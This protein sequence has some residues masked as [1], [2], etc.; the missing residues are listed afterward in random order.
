MADLLTDLDAALADDPELSLEA[1]FRAPK[2]APGTPVLSNRTP[3][4][5]RPP[6]QKPDR[7]SW[8]VD[9]GW[10]GVAGGVADGIFG[11]MDTVQTFDHSISARL[12]RTLHST[13]GIHLPGGATIDADGKYRFVNASESFES[14]KSDRDGARAFMKT[15]LFKEPERTGAKI[16]RDISEFAANFVPM[17]V[18]TEGMAGW[19]YVAAWSRP[20]LASA[21]AAYQ[22]TDPLEGNLANVAEHFG[23]EKAAIS[24]MLHVDDLV[25]ALSVEQDDSEFE[26]RLKNMA[27]D[28]VVGVAADG[29]FKALGTMIGA[30]RKV[31]VQKAELEALEGAAEVKPDVNTA[32]IREA[33]EDDAAGGAKTLAEGAEPPPSVAKPEGP[34]VPQDAPAGTQGELFERPQSAAPD[35]LDEFERVHLDVDAKVRGMTEVELRQLAEDQ[36][37]GRGFTMLERMGVNP[38]RLDF[39][40]FLAKHPNAAE[41]MEALHDWVARIATAAEPMS[42]Q[43]GSKPRTAET[44]AVLARFLG[45]D[46]KTISKTF[47]DKTKNLDVYANAAAGLIGGEAEK[48]VVLAEKAVPR[49]ADAG[50]PEYIAFLKQLETVS[51]LQA[52]F[53]GSASNMGRGLRSLQTIVESRQG[54]A[55]I[56]RIKSVLGKDPAD[57]TAKIGKTFEDRLT[58]LGEAKTPAARAKLLQQI[59]KQ[60]GDLARVVR[61]ATKYSGIVGKLRV[62]RETSANLFSPATFT[63]N[64]LGGA[65]M[66]TSDIIA[67]STSHLGAALFRSPE[68]VAAA[69]SN[70]AYLGSLLPSL[71]HGTVRSTQYLARESIAEVRAATEGLGTN[72]ASAKLTQASS[73]VERQ[74]GK[75]P[76]W[77]ADKLGKEATLG[78]LR[79]KFERADATRERLWHIAPTTVDAWNA[80]DNHGAAFLTAGL[81]SLTG[82]A[83]NTFGAIS[84]S[85]RVLAID[86][87]DELIGQTV[88]DASRYAEA[89]RQ[90]TLQG[91]QLGKS[92]TDLASFAERQAKQLVSEASDDTLT[93]LEQLVAAGQQDAGKIKLLAQEALDRTNIE[94]VAEADARRILFQDDLKT[95]VAQGASRA[96]NQMDPGG[97]IVPFV[98]TPL[99]IIE[100]AA[101]EFTPAGLFFR[102]ARETIAAGGPEAAEMIARM[103]LG[104][105]LI[106]EGY[107]RAAKGDVVGY[108]GGPTSSSRLGRP[109]YSIRLPGGNHWEFGRIDPLAIPLGLGADLYEWEQRFEDE[110]K[111]H[112]KGALEKYTYAVMHAVTSSVLSK[113][114]L[115]S[116]QNFSA[117]ADPK[118]GDYSREQFFNGLM[119]RMVPAGGFQKYAAQGDAD[120]IREAKTLAEKYRASWVGL[121][122]ALPVRRDPLLGKVVEFNRT[123]GFRRGEDADD[124]LI[125]EVSRLNFEAPRDTRAI[126][127][128]QLTAKHSERLKAL[129]GEEVRLGGLTLDGRLRAH[130]ANPRWR[131]MSDYQ[132]VE[133]IRDTREMYAD[134]AKTRLQQEDKGLAQEVKVQS[135]IRLLEQRG[136]TPDELPAAVQ[137]FR[138]EA[139][140]QE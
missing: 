48:L 88:F 40:K 82:L 54:L 45:S 60:R 14:Y 7:P 24:K 100:S 56:S 35:V 111:E 113:S 33:V 123:A 18:A 125:A 101:M 67:A 12:D 94:S 128:V 89:V 127:G 25:G 90:A 2:P 114:W 110:D 21:V 138:K 65:G 80:S 31:K 1:Q 77:E 58:A 32:A 5:Y 46:I 20:I 63:F 36:A 115:K 64:I 50:S 118:T 68:W 122:A 102:E 75:I 13:L 104:T 85:A 39:G 44:T 70:R 87:P 57:A 95:G 17:M 49:V 84:R 131:T 16:T 98:K 30:L 129:M 71:W 91:L 62:F 79:P 109:Q 28:G 53:R 124:Q 76:V 86:V 69:A 10:R 26:A 106:V 73:W 4:P 96:L 55:K 22:K 136:T 93:R 97:I 117:M 140:S 52:A 120:A 137:R 6:A 92:G 83:F 34:S 126:A 134:V 108:D 9:Y 103:T 121:S 8:A 3:E 81:R 72:V 59:L 47:A 99:R 41:A 43:L 116:L 23:I 29:A 133:A 37:A 27:A 130:M 119:Q 78:D 139:L 42:L 19:G 61:D 107:T 38:A 51:V 105:M 132:R 112:T 66:I 11:L 74:F 135:H 15:T